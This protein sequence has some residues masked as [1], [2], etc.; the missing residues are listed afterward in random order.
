MKIATSIVT[1]VDVKVY[2]FIV[3]LK[4]AHR[5]VDLTMLFFGV[6]QGLVQ[7]IENYVLVFLSIANNFLENTN[8]VSLH[9]VL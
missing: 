8:L 6:L 1:D 2:L 4:N 9:L 5:N 7:E 3:H